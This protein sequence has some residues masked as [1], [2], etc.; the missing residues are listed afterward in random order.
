MK[1]LVSG[2]LA[3]L[4]LL[5][6]VIT[7]SYPVFAEGEENESRNALEITPSGARLTFSPGEVLEGNAAHC[8]VGDGGCSITVRNI[9]TGHVNFKVYISPY[10][11]RGEENELS[12]SEEDSTDYTR[13]YEWITV[14][15]N[16]GEYVKEAVFGLEPKESYTVKYRI[17]VPED[18]P[19]GS[20]YAVIWAQ[21]VNDGTSGGI[22]TV[23]QIGAVLTARSTE[24]S[25]ETAEISDYDFTKFTFSGPLHATATVKNTG[26]VDFAAKYYYTAKT[27]FGK[28]LYKK[29]DFVAAYPGTTYHINVDW[30]RDGDKEK[31]GEDKDSDGK[32]KLP[33][34]G[35]FQVEWRVVAADRTRTETAVVIVM[36]IIVIIAVILLLTVII[37][38]IIIISRTRKERKARKLV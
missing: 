24:D 21:I 30:S 6:G 23:G 35:I 25:V 27:I 14:E 31:D 11:V 12:F 37:I 16:D 17:Q 8:P 4:L 13:L 22:E 10:I 7:S 19:G 32:G 33:F 3:G 5:G 18:A 26:N 38:W 2:I 28:E 36:P 1:K 9:G 29:E 20:Q 15:N 34:L